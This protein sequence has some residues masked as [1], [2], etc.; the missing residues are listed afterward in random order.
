MNSGRIS[1]NFGITCLSL[2]IATF[3]FRMSKQGR[4]FPLDLRTGT[5]EFSHVVFPGAGSM[6][7]SF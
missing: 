1:S 3:A 2:S 7:S 6:M 5:T 4:I